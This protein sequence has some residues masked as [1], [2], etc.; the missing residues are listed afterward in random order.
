[1]L[2]QGKI[3]CPHCGWNK[4]HDYEDSQKVPPTLNRVV[5]IRSSLKAP[6]FWAKVVL[7][8]MKEDHIRV[9][10]CRDV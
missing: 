2:E 5:R 4:E 1:M 8:E 7:I 9:W 3:Q 6:P 10:Y